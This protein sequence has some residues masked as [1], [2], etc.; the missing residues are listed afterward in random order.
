MSWRTCGEDIGKWIRKCWLVNLTLGKPSNV[1]ALRTH[2]LCDDWIVGHNLLPAFCKGS[3]RWRQ[4]KVSI[5]INALQSKIEMCQTHHCVVY[6]YMKNDHKQY[7]MMGEFC[8]LLNPRVCNCYLI[9]SKI[10]T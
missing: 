3:K 7:I 6:T 5:K 9:L 2:N 10:A 4:K 1:S 8:R